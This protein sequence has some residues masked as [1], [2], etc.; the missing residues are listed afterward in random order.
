MAEEQEK[1]VSGTNENEQE[2]QFG[3]QKIYV[4]DIS[5][6]IPHSPMVFQ[7]EWEPTV[8]MDIANTASK[9]A[10]DIYEAVLSVTLTVTSAEKTMYLIEAQQAGIFHIAGLPN[11]AI[12]KMLAT[13]CPNIIFPFVRELISDMVM[14]GGFP[15]LLLA[16]VNFDAL[17]AQ[18]AEQ[19][20][21]QQDKA[22][23]H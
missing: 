2:A 21:A 12:N 22:T 9:V 23:T 1:Q 13:T 10:D 19:E 16:P 20:A 11:D 7:E 18:K 5:F 8:N 4:K 3:L 15:Q 6:E 14:R 17:Y